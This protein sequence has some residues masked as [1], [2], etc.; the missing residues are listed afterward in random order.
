MDS[1]VYY[2]AE[3]QR[4][5]ATADASRRNN[6]SPLACFLVALSSSVDLL[7]RAKHLL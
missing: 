5:G 6:P 3:V 2:A 4:L 1:L 7:L